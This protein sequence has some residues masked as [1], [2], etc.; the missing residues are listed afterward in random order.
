MNTLLHSIAAFIVGSSKVSHREEFQSVSNSARYLTIYHED[1]VMW[2][3]DTSLSEGNTVNSEEQAIRAK[4]S[5][6]MTL[7]IPMSD[8]MHPHF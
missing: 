8:R 5:V 7:P 3:T 4:R 2:L 6:L 1:M